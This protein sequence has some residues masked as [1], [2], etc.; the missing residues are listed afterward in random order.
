MSAKTVFTRSA[1]LA[2]AAGICGAGFLISPPAHA[3]GNID[4]TVQQ[5]PT[6][7]TVTVHNTGATL[8]DCTY[9]AKPTNN[10]LLP[11]VHREFHLTQGSAPDATKELDFLAP[12]LGVTYHLVVACSDSG[13]PISHF[14]QDVTGSL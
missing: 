6:N 8:P 13:N 14:E 2:A 5:T 9:D 12:P 3:D 4:V 1:V 10:P 11:P 7:V